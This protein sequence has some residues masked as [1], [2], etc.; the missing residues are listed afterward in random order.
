MVEELWSSQNA[1]FIQENHAQVKTQQTSMKEGLKIFR[2]DGE[3][4]VKSKMQQPHD[5]NVMVPVRI[6]SSHTN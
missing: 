2:E 1:V 4:A 6:R 3:V 5:R